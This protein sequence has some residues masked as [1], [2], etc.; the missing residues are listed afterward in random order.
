MF[1]SSTIL[2]E[3]V[4]NLVKVTLYFVVRLYGAV[5]ADM[6]PQHHIT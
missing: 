4:W 5:A 6:L 3:L 2:R 1:R